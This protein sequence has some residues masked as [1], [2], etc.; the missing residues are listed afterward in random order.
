MVGRP[1]KETFLRMLRENTLKNCPVTDE[2]AK[3][4]VFI[5]GRDIGAIRGKTTRRTPRHVP[6]VEAIVQVP[7]NILS[8]HGRVTLSFDIFF[9]DKIAFLVTIAR[10]IRF[11]TTE[12]I[13]SR[14]YTNVTAALGQVVNPYKLR[15]LQIVLAHC[16]DEFKGLYAAIMD[17]GILLNPAANNEHVPEVER[18]IRT[19]KERNRS[20]VNALPYTKYP[21]EF[22]KALIANAVTWINMFPHADGIS[23]VLSPRAIVTGM[24]PDYNIHCRVPIGTKCEVHNDPKQELHLQSR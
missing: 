7:D 18:V 21:K 20:S 24:T 23:N 22:K 12:C 11:V 17:F 8:T 4:A 9:V 19:I 3:R 13:P 16:D 1:S 10:D 15:G 2:D 5:Y 6:G 14:E